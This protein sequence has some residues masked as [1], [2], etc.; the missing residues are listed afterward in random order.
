MAKTFAENA[1]KLREQRER[2]A[3]GPEAR[4]GKCF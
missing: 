1:K 2:E 4:G 3:N